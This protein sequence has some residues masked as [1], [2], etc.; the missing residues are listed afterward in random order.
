MQM[1]PESTEPGMQGAAMPEVLCSISP[2]MFCSLSCKDQT[3]LAHSH[4]KEG[5]P[6]SHQGIKPPVRPEVLEAL[7]S[8]MAAGKQCYMAYDNEHLKDGARKIKPTSWIRHGK[9]FKALCYNTEPPIEKPFSARK[10][11]RVE[12]HKWDMPKAQSLG[13]LSLTHSIFCLSFFYRQSKRGQ[14]RHGRGMA[15][16]HEPRAVLANVRRAW[17]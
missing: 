14:G 15:Q 3:G 17:L 13:M 16:D 8:T 4:H 5:P 1:W 7:I 11:L 10:V 6:G 9:C 12:D 2:D